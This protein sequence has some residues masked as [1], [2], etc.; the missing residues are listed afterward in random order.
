M[1]PRRY[2]AGSGRA[3]LAALA[4]GGAGAAWSRCGGRSHRSRGRGRSGRY[5][6]RRD[7]RGRRGSRRHGRCRGGCRSP[8]TRRDRQ[9]LAREDQVGVGDPVGAHQCRHRGA[10]PARKR[11]E[12]VTRSNDVAAP[13]QPGGGGGGG[14]AGHRRRSRGQRQDLAGQDQVGVGDA[15]G[16]HQC[17]DG[18]AVAAGNAAQR[19]AGPHDVPGRSGPARRSGA[20][21]GDRQ[22]LAREDQVGVGDVVGRDQRRDRRPGPAGD[23]AQRVATNHGVRR[24]RRRR[25]RP[26]RRGN[27]GHGGRRTCARSR[28]DPADRGNADTGG[29]ADAQQPQGLGTPVLLEPDDAM[30]D[31]A[32]LEDRQVAPDQP[33]HGHDGGQ[34]PAQGPAQQEAAQGPVAH[35][36]RRGRRGGPSRVV[37][38]D[39]QLHLVFEGVPVELVGAAR[40][41]AEGQIHL[42]AHPEVAQP[43]D[44]GQIAARQHGEQA[45][46]P[47]QRA[48]ARGRQHGGD[49]RHA[50]QDRQ[51]LP[52][53]DDDLHVRRAESRRSGRSRP[54][55]RVSS[56]PRRPSGR[57]TSGPRRPQWSP[58]RS[59]RS[60]YRPPPSPP[61][62]P[63]RPRGSQVDRD[64]NTVSSP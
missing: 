3:D 34:H 2:C 43:S 55:G 41:G 48:D 20:G 46:Q 31:P 49:H 33:D 15:V 42:A 19:V 5:R 56:R 16:C 27:G 14:R 12:G 36:Y 62:P 4:A 60:T 7:G 11:R 50:H 18:R 28:R 45:G 51:H 22:D 63:S 26:G 54:S 6:F 37:I 9:Q 47:P 23:G 53:A 61:P 30:G 40:V 57:V 10:V 35:F 13:R 38:G 1:P 24:C 59:L 64:R 58:Q 25:R 29:R 32:A 17:C 52:P 44:Q 8:T 39:R 21:T